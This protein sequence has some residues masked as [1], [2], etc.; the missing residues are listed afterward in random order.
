MAQPHPRSCPRRLSSEKTARNRT[1]C[2]AGKGVVA[3]GRLW[4][5]KRHKRTIRERSF[6]GVVYV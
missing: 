5:K 2:A 4:K 6:P 3:C 1:T